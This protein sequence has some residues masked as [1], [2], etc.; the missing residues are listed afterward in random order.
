MR[1]K[2]ARWF[3]I[4]ALVVALAPATSAPGQGQITREGRYWV[5]EVA[6][7]IPAAP[8]VRVVSSQGTI[9]LRGGPETKI[10]YRV[11]KRVRAS[12]EEEA[13]RKLSGYRL[14]A[15]R[16][17]ELAELVV[18]FGH[19]EG[20]GA[21]CFVTVPRS[22]LRAHLETR[23]G[24][25]VVEKIDGEAVATT[26]GGSIRADEI[27]AG[28]RL[29][30][31]GG[32]ITMGRMGGKVDAQTAGGSIQLQS[33]GEAVLATRG[34][35]ITVGACEK[36]VRAETAGGGIRVN[37]AG[38]NVLAETAGG[39]I[40]IGEAGARVTAQTSG[41]SI[42]V[43]SARGLVRAETAAGGIRLWKLAGPVH[44]E[45][46]AGSIVA[47]VVADRQSWAESQLETSVGDVTVYLPEALAVTI[48]ASIEMASG[49]H[50]IVTDFPLTIRTVSEAPGPKEI[51]GEGSLNGGG[52]PLRIRTTSGNIEIRKNK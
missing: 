36:G 17:G 26:A 42:T 39:S 13:R 50:R 47:Q 31:A 12:S 29:E 4:P 35:S 14:R 16:S 5:E 38:G 46:A 19:G 33:C 2:G 28:A 8:R 43:D 7:D 40:H 27:S 9:E 41:G 15:G 52:A 37:R 6:G 24:S 32:S 20:A 21:E 25:V 3:L 48:R 11:R 22:T 49:R 1:A 44:A 10:S 45:T 51:V 30:T 34:G 18:E 23:G